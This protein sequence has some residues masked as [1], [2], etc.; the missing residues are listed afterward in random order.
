[1]Q[2]KE[3][4][5]LYLD[6]HA[7]RGGY[8]LAL[9]STSPSGKERVPEWPTGI[10][11]LWREGELPAAIDDYL[12][13][14]RRFNE[15]KGGPAG[16][17]QYYPGSPWLAKLSLRPQDRMA[18]FE[19]RADDSEA[20][21]M[22]FA[23]EKG[24][25]VHMM[26]GYSG[27]KAQLPP[28]ERRALVFV[29]PPFESKGEFGHIERGVTEALRRIPDAVIAIWYPMTS[30]SGAD[31][32]YRRIEALKTPVIAVELASKKKSMAVTTKE[33][34]VLIMN[35]PWGFSNEM[36]LYL[37]VLAR[38]LSPLHELALRWEWLVADE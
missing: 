36:T 38:A 19:L 15:R 20:L 17:L 29:D 6:T 28:P 2:R 11:K 8:E 32:F 25:K 31:F 7:G 37:D 21:E 16:T 23:R 26:D 3:K 34:G 33:C 22:E 12:S 4:G 35:P 24:V 1:M 13:L 10:G 27:L 9:Q 14:V 30:R 5:F 18:L